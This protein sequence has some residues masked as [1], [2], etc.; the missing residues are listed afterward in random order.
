MFAPSHHIFTPRFRTGSSTQSSRKSRASGT[1]DSTKATKRR[2]INLVDDQFR[3]S[4]KSVAQQG[5]L[6]ENMTFCVLESDFVQNLSGNGNGN[7][8]TG[9]STVRKF[10][11]EDVSNV[12]L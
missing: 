5:Q 11:R 10:T 2:K 3:V 1:G 4:S 7:N 12:T 8:N 9:G 6:F